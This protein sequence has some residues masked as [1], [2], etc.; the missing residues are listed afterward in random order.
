MSH[1]DEER[2]KWDSMSDEDHLDLMRADEARSEY[3]RVEARLSNILLERYKKKKGLVGREYNH[4]VS[5]WNA[6]IEETELLIKKLLKKR[7]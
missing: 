7:K 5:Y 1:Y 4:S 2:D 3:C 6:G